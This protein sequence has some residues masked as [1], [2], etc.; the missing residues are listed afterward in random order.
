MI[1]IPSEVDVLVVG[2][3]PGGSGAAKRCAELGLKVL[4]VEK[5]AEIGAPKRCG[6]AISRNG[7]TERIG[8]EPRGPWIIQEVH[9]AIVYAPNGKSITMDYK[10]PEGWIIERK[11]FDKHL[12]AEAAKAGARVLAKVEARGF[13][14]ADGKVAATLEYEGRTFGVTAKIV[15]AADGIESLVA[16]ELGINTGNRLMDICA[17]VQFEM[18]G[19]RTKGNMIEFFFSNKA[20]PGGYC[21]TPSTEIITKNTVKS[22]TEVGLGED[23]LSLDGWTPAEAKSVRDYEGDVIAIKPYMINNEA[24]LTPDH[25]VYA[26]NRKCGFSWKKACELKKGSRGKHMEGDYLVFPVPKEEGV[27]FL[28][29]GKYAKGIECEGKI[30]PVGRNQFGAKFKY[31]YGIPSNIELTNDLMEFFGYYV[32]E[33]SANSGGIIISNTD[34]NIIRRV[35]EVGERIFGVKVC[36]WKNKNRE[37]PCF[38]A[39]FPSKIL[40][41]LFVGMFKEGCRNKTFPRFFSGLSNGLKL[42][43]LVGLFR[44]D[45]DK[46]KKSTGLEHLEYTSTSKSLIYDMWMLLS[47][48]GIVGA[49]GRIRK[50]DAYKLRIYGKQLEKLEKIFGRCKYGNMQT[51]RSFIKDGFVFMG[52]NKIGT[53]KYSGKVYDIQSNGSFC[54]GFIIHNCWIFPKGDGVANVGIGVRKPW[55]KKTALEY[56]EDFV[57]S[58]PELK[59][60]SILEVNSGGVPVGGFLDD[61]VADN[62]M[63][64]GDAAH[65]VNPIHGGGIPE[66]Y[67]AGRLAAETA[68]EAVK[69]GDFSRKFLKRYDQRWEKERGSRLKKILK[70]REVMENMSDEDLNWLVDYLQGEDL[71]EFSRGSSGFGK[72]A[73]ILMKKPKLIKLARKLV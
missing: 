3:G 53:E 28:E 17:G 67:M 15:I 61:A 26:W 11:M 20:A 24:K 62:L 38:Q 2:M 65:H 69:A 30:Y 51:G 52:I 9:G 10:G 21:V 54:P 48:M 44:G 72:L 39:A 6:E 55:A 47:T 35:S 60:A 23:V 56:L 68:A 29:V 58:R 71:V 59:N 33:G 25:L 49:I 42:S 73:K 14:R 1:E 32:S 37:K 41:Q 70:L 36:I 40:K 50:K 45:G 31:K 66:A 43:F 64:V 57:N 46:Y 34:E 8:I 12:A 7:M 27:R 13:R 19:V 16:R 5:R 4:G 22:I 18:A 63:V